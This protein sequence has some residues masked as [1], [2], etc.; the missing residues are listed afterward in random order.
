MEISDNSF[1]LLAVA[2]AVLTCRVLRPVS[3][4]VTCTSLLIELVIFV[5]NNTI[6]LAI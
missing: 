1:G 4:F 2:L 3:W 6:K 5:D